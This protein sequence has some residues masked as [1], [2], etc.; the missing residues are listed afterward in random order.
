MSNADKTTYMEAA[1]C[2]L[3][4]WCSIEESRN[5]TGME[6]VISQA[7]AQDYEAKIALGW[8]DVSDKF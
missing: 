2:K 1:F 5:L 7:T 8:P 6:R 3:L 4:S